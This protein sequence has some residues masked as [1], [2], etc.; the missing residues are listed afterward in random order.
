MN[1]NEMREL[2]KKE[3]AI[4]DRIASMDYKLN[5]INK[6]TAIPSKHIT[7]EISDGYGKTTVELHTGVR[8]D[9]ELVDGIRDIIQNRRDAS[10]AELDNLIN[11]RINKVM[12][13]LRDE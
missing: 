12:E 5:T 9:A 7:I 3:S 4:S 11:G 6:M 8:Q 10:V 1:V 2:V 13:V